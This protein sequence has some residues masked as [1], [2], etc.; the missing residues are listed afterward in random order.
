[1]P[2]LS[3]SVADFVALTTIRSA[4]V[5]TRFNDIATLL[6]TTKL[7]ADNLQDNAVTGPKLASDASVDA[8]RAVD[9]DHIKDEA[10]A[11]AKIEDEAV[12]AAKINFANVATNNQLILANRVFN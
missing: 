11:T 3:Y 9:T 2:A 12:T 4:D 7:D 8:N 10:I 6:N 1:M 5:N